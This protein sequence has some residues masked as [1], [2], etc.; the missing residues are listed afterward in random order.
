MIITANGIFKIVR[1][2][3]SIGGNSSIVYVSGTAGGA[4]IQLAYLDDFDTYV[5]LANGIISA[6]NQYVAEHGYS[7]DVYVVISG[8]TGAT[9]LAIVTKRRS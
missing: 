3:R 7:S 6:G 8:A 9:N 5:P 2:T 1:A 4:S